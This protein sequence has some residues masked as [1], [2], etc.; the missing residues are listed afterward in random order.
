MPERPDIA[1]QVAELEHELL[2]LAD[3]LSSRS[4]IFTDASLRRDLQ[5]A[6]AE[7]RELAGMNRMVDQPVLASE[8]PAAAGLDAGGEWPC[9]CRD[10]G[11]QALERWGTEPA[12]A[13]DIATRMLAAGRPSEQL[14]L[15]LAIEPRFQEV[16][17]PSTAAP[18][19]AGPPDPIAPQG[20]CAISPHSLWGLARA[21]P[22]GCST[23]V[24]PLRRIQSVTVGS[25]PNWTAPASRRRIVGSPPPAPRPA[26]VR[27]APPRAMPTTFALVVR[28]RERFAGCPCGT[29]RSEIGALR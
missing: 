29:A 17:P 25:W 2:S 5:T 12:E 14:A 3:R 10:R 18:R 13:R 23:S 27:Q 26:R 20:A 22:R 15:W 6:A 24:E 16:A 1:E 4:I 9:R 19:R 7:L 11:A 28:S 8:S 21:P